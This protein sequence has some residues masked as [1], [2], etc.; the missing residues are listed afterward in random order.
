MSGGARRPVR[1][2]NTAPD[3]FAPRRNLESRSPLPDRPF[4]KGA[5][6]PVK[7][8]IFLTVAMI[9]PFCWVTAK[10]VCHGRFLSRR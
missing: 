8:M 6:P 3:F 4:R 2:E 5:R 9:A 1:P 7:P 10:A